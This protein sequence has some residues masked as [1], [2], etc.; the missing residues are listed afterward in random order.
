[1]EAYNELKEGER[2]AWTSIIAYI[3][4]SALKLWI[5]YTAGSS[6]LTAD[7]LNNTTDLVASIAVLIGLRISRRPPDK[8]HPYGH[9][10]A[11]TVAALVA[12]FIMFAVGIQVFAQAIGS[13]GAPVIETPDMIAAWTALACAA[14]MY[15][16][17]LYNI[18]LARKINNKALTAAA[19]DNRSDAYVSL[20]AFAGI[21]GAQ[22]GL[23][24]LDPCTA[25]LVA[26]L[27]C[28]TAW[29]IFIDAAHALTDGFDD[30]KLESFKN[31]VAETPG[32][33]SIEDLRARVHGNQVLVDVVIVVD[34]RLNVAQSH[35]I[36]EHVEKRMFNK[37]K[38]GHVHVHIEPSSS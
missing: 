11:E 16:V 34:H 4:L 37:H 27:I 1:M 35:D 5:G 22:M 29:G 18:R 25:L 3:A 20:A 21:L 13:F 7:G 19:Y 24:W 9:F 31:T 6:A 14:V 33:E 36:A 32:V 26:I 23:P 30:T 15:G 28:K 2:G 38:V 17:Y 12:S 8:D 10:R